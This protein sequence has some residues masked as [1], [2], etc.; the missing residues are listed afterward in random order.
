MG[1]FECLCFYVI[2]SHNSRVRIFPSA[3]VMA[4]KLSLNIFFYCGKSCLL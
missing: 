1:V 3:L 2:I 4:H